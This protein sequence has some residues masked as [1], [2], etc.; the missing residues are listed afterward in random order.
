MQ[1]HECANPDFMRAKVWSQLLEFGVEF[2]VDTL[3]T[4][5]ELL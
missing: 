4:R 5:L 3:E 1:S 2:L